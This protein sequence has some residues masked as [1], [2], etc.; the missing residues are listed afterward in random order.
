[1]PEMPEKRGELARETVKAGTRCEFELT[2]ETIDRVLRFMDD[3]G[4]VDLEGERE[5]A[6]IFVRSLLLAACDPNH[7]VKE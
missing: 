4:W 1:M 3:S 5:P 2:D 6:R 7:V